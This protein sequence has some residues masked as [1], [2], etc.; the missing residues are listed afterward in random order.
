MQILVTIL[1]SATTWEA[2]GLI[3]AVLLLC[4]HR[5]RI[6]ITNWIHKNNV[7]IQ[8]DIQ[9]ATKLEEDASLLLK[10]YQS[11]ALEQKKQ[12]EILKQ[13]NDQELMLMKKEINEKTVEAIQQQN[14]ATN[15]HIRLVATQHQQK[16]I[17]GLLDK[18]TKNITSHFQKQ[19][20]E[21][22]DASIQHL[23]DSL[24]KNSNI[25]NQL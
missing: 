11:Q 4:N 1:T 23:F 14:E 13:Q 16:M 9:S 7:Q 3:C 21:N 10:Q 15:I 6:W 18:L 20:K 12:L 8:E 22:M 19:K 25:L 17:A 5:I 24:E 2:M